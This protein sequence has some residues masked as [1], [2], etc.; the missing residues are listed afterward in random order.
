MTTTIRIE[1]KSKAHDKTAKVIV[2]EKPFITDSGWSC[3]SRTEYTLLK[4]GAVLEIS[5]Y[6]NRS[7]Q[8][9]EIDTPLEAG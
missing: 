1:L 4:Q 6:N 5:V 8:I 9:I 7:I 3:D 2:Q